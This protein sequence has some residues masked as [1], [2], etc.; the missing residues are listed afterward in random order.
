[1]TS[2]DFDAQFPSR[3][4]TPFPACRHGQKQSARSYPS[5]SLGSKL[6]IFIIVHRSLVI[7]PLNGNFI[8]WNN[9]VRS[10]HGLLRCTWLCRYNRLTRR[11]QPRERNWSSIYADLANNIAQLRRFIDI[12]IPQAKQLCHEAVEGHEDSADGAQKGSQMG[13]AP[14]HGH[15]YK[16]EF[17]CIRPHTVAFACF[18]DQGVGIPI[19]H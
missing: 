12:T 14:E 2:P 9:T 18:G 6:K 5:Q 1:M 15:G 13:P 17:G 10:P 19:P 8:L 11:R 16:G 3:S 4:K 7:S